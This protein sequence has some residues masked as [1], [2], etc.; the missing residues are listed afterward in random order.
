[1]GGDFPGLCINLRPAFFAIS[2]AHQALSLGVTPEPLLGKLIGVAE[3]K[4]N[5]QLFRLFAM[6]LLYFFGANKVIDCFGIG[7]FVLGAGYLYP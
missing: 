6:D 7:T 2:D 4:H 5:W 1:V 3:G